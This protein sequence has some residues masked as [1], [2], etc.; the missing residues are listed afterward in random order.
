MSSLE[1]DF[2][3]DVF[4]IALKFST[5]GEDNGD[6]GKLELSEPCGLAPFASFICDG[7]LGL[8]SGVLDLATGV[9]DLVEFGERSPVIVVAVRGLYG[10]LGGRLK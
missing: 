10:L 4:P 9:L 6:P 8:D 3:P 1:A 5:V 2:T 7:V